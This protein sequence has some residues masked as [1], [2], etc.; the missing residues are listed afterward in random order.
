MNHRPKL[1]IRCLGGSLALAFALV[2]CGTTM[3]DGQAKAPVGNGGFEEGDRWGRYESLRFGFSI[4][5]PDG[6][7]WRIDD[8]GS[9]WLRAT[10]AASDSELSA[11]S[12]DEPRA[13][14]RESCLERARE[15]SPSV[16]PDLA[17]MAV[18]DDEIRALGSDRDDAS[19]HIRV[20]VASGK[21]GEQRGAVLVSAVSIRRCFS[22]VITT[23]AS[24]PFAETAVAERLATLASF[25]VPSVRFVSPMDVSGSDAIKKA[26]PRRE[27]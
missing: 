21:G 16:I 10:H 4:R 22:M 23:R 7:G 11:R 18:I 14:S 19:A 8:H 5:L 24:G 27:P 17:E 25:V 12:W 6:R 2:G 1:S 20:A 3:L 13:V 15:L 26:S 9:L